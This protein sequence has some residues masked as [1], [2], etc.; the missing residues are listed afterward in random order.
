MRDPDRIMPF[1]EELGNIW[2][3]HPDLRFGQ[4]MTN[5]FYKCGDPF[6]FEEDKFLH[7]LK[8]YMSATTNI[9]E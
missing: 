5:F 2:R 3:K 7:E 4:L 9:K 6:Y 1:L 8:K